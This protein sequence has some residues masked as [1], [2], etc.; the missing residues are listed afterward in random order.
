MA[1]STLSSEAETEA[2][3]LHANK[4][5]P[6]GQPTGQRAGPSGVGGWLTFFCVSITVLWPLMLIAELSFAIRESNNAVGKT[7]NFV[8]FVGLAAYSIVTGVRTWRGKPDAIR[9][10]KIYLLVSLGI[11][12]VSSIA[13]AGTTSSAEFA[14]SVL[15]YSGAYFL[16]WWLY[17]SRSKRVRNT[18][19]QTS[20]RKNRL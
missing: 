6:E 7:I 12:I 20:I 5:S 14:I 8:L 2:A 19:A 9:Q 3:G 16:V 13:V 18:F 10:A 15:I 4:E 11:S 17:L 1:S